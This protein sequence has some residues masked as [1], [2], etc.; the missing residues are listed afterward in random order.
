[1][2]HAEQVNVHGDAHNPATLISSSGGE[3]LVDQ[4]GSILQVATADNEGASS[5][6]DVSVSQSAAANEG[7]TYVAAGNDVT[8]GSSGWASA[9]GEGGAGGAAVSELQI[10]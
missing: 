5:L 6:N 3:A 2:N 1:M 9:V 7:L 4:Y 8:A 10:S